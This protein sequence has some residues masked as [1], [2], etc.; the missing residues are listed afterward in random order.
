VRGCWWWLKG[1]ETWYDLIRSPARLSNCR[2]HAW[3]AR[4]TSIKQHK[5]YWMVSILVLGTGTW[6]ETGVYNCNCIG[7][8]EDRF[9][10]IERRTSRTFVLAWM[11]KHYSCVLALTEASTLGVYICICI[12]GCDGTFVGST[13][14]V[15]LAH[16][17]VVVRVEAC[18]GGFCLEE[19]L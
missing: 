10:W 9:C 13:F 18:S 7:I 8:T 6:V 12:G 19:L 1:N 15:A 16:D 17:K 11:K 5:H 3:P 14:S 2:L 4:E